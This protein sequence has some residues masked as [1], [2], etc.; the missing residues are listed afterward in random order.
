MLEIILYMTIG[1]VLFFVGLHFS[2]LGLKKSTG[3]RLQQ[4]LETFTSNIIA[5]II[6][7]AIVTSVIQSSSAVT[8]MVI[9]FVNGGVMTIYQGMGV[10]IGSNIGTTI[11]MHILSLK[12]NY[13]E[14]GLL[15]FGFAVMVLGWIKRKREISYGGLVSIG[16][17]LIFLGLEL[18]QTG[19]TPLQYNPRIMGWLM[20]FGDQ[21][22][23][24]IFSGLGFTALIQSSS[25][26]SGIVLSIARQGM[27]TLKGAIA[28]ILGSNVGTCV[29][30]LLAAMKTNKIARRV[31]Y[32][33]V[34]FNI[35]GV[36][37]FIPILNNF[38]ILVSRFSSDL[39]CQIAF[40]H[41]IFNF[42]TAII[43]LPFL[44]FLEHLLNDS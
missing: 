33:H 41:T 34:I 8:V 20:K 44:R 9:G 10:I 42:T 15:L 2:E 22:I 12:I 16:F 4:I 36:L 28:I 32:F 40:S 19:V 13:L 21:P 3:I 43:I 27:M 37:F 1:L 24:G 25:A 5:G 14:S 7:G 39:G 38:S 23:L 26:T 18:I 35:F 6:T 31:A 30:A 29:T 11:T 17:G